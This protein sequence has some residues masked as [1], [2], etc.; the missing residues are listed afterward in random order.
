MRKTFVVILCLIMLMAFSPEACRADVKIDEENFPDRTF[1][2]VMFMYD[3]D[4]D[5]TLSEDEI[6]SIKRL[7]LSGLGISDIKGVGHLKA[8]QILSCNENSL[9]VL[10]VSGC[11]ALLELSCYKNHLT[12]LNVNGCKA[13]QKID[14]D[15]NQLTVLNLM[16]L[17][18]SEC[19][20]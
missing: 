1:R 11:T 2:S 6:N 5:G 3:T 14:C 20:Q 7:Y 19:P 18:I 4:R 9:N 10:D 17:I 15:R 8:L 12:T 16:P 13:L